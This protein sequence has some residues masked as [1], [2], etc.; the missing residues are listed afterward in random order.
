MT[1]LLELHD[2]SLGYNHNVVLN[3][4]S[5]SVRPGE[6]VAVFGS[7]GS[8]KSTLARGIAGSMPVSCGYIFLNGVDVT[9]FGTAERCKL[10][11]RY[12]PQN[13]HVFPHLSIR[14]NILLCNPRWTV[15]KSDK[16]SF[17]DRLL[18]DLTERLDS[19]AGELSGGQ[20]QMLAIMRSL[21]SSPRLLLLDEPL[22][23]LSESAAHSILAELR[24]ACKAGL[25]IVI[26]E[27][28]EMV[29]AVCDR[30]LTLS[31]NGLVPR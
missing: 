11:L 18:M 28:R 15:S 24:R 4:I 6:M 1:D 30:S 17:I 25:A 31:S 29:S 3:A 20:Q 26:I 19:N 2:V 23:S 5:L 9:Q 22:S 7:N 8:G 21:V 16:E 12:C 27:H 14:D 13:P 10:G